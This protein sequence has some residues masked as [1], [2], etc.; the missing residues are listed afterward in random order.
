MINQ[1]PMVEVVN[2][3]FERY[4]G[5]VI[6]DRAICDVRDMLK[7]SARMLIYSQMSITKN[8]H[9]K[10]FIK[11]ARVVGDCLGHLYEHG[12][13]SCY[14]SYMRMSKDFT[15][16]VPLEECQGNNGTMTKNGDE[17]AMRYTELRLSEIASYLYDGLDKNA[18]GNNWRNNFDETERYPGVMPSIGYFNLCN[19]TQ[20]LGIAISSSIPQFSLKE[21]NEAIIKL[22]QNPDASDE[23]IIIM[24]DFATGGNLI[25]AKEVFESLKNGTGSACKLRATLT[26]SPDSNIILITELPYGVYSEVIKKQVRELMLDDTYGIKSIHD[27]TGKTPE[28]EIELN[29][30]ANPKKMIAKLFKDTSLENHFTINMWVL[31]DGRFPQIMGLRQIFQE[32]ITHI[33]TCKRREIQFDLDKALARKNIVDG[34]IRAYSII[35]DVVAT[36]RASASPSEASTQLIT[37]FQFN[38]EQAKAILAMKLSS[39]TRLDIIK[40]NN[41]QEELIQKIEWCQH[42]LSDSTSLDEELI[43][44]LRSV[45]EQ[46]GDERRT[47]ILNIVEEEEAPE[48]EQIQEEDVGIMLFDN[49]MIRLV[50]R[51]D[52]QGG[53]RGKKGTNIKPPK[54]ANLINT[55]YTTNLSLVSAFTTKGKMY[56]FSITDLDYGKDYSIY[57]L[58][59]LQDSEKVMLIIDTTSFN[60]Y[61]YLVTISKNGYI[62]KTSVKEYGSRAKKGIAAVKLEN[63]NLVGV[64]LSSN[65]NDKIFVASN[66]GN[67][68]YY[69]LS[70]ISATGRVTRGVRAIKLSTN[71]YIQSATII[72]ADLEYKGLLT[73][74]SSGKGKITAIE[75]FN[76][77]SR[78][79]KGPQVMSVKDDSLAVIYA[80]P[81]TQDKLFISAN[82]KAVL[83]N[84]D[85]IPVQ[86]RATTGVRIIDVRGM[87]S[88]IEIM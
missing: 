66:V 33:R 78:A 12:E 11:S 56:N 71:D 52:L 55:L 6:L 23:E 32:Y 50:K 47:K 45:A 51:E 37:K 58:I 10:P 7:P 79:V 76:E 69:P 61:H 2:E 26:Y 87:N 85:S 77:T 21:V 60:S 5:N 72:K 24:P 63:D 1:R 54:G 29:K 62:K 3:N 22:I 53:K 67:Y 27:N 59:A 70:E 81:S 74:T 28:I 73:I 19:G 44:I 18:I 40:L 35:D 84:V 4:A 82:N 15:M 46:F 88:T 13:S 9:K 17:A 8:T 36:I 68:N 86:N 39:L 75:D 65:E 48:K 64:Y 38:E 16:R 80:V 30:G 42:L 57:E 25:N 49:N 31:K 34:L 20:G 41:E 43:K 83:L 14:G